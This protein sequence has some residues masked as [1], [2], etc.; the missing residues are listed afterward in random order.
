MNPPA[1]A[2]SG[3]LCHDPLANGTVHGGSDLIEAVAG[4]WVED[5]ALELPG[6]AV[7]ILRVL[8]R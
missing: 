7:R 6:D 1:S 2:C 5:Q 3:Q 8:R 4:P